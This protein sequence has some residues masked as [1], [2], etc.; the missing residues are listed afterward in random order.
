MKPRPSDLFCRVLS[1]AIVAVFF[2]H[3]AQAETLYGSNNDSRI[4]VALEVNQESVQSQ[5]PEGWSAIPFPGG[6]LAGANTLLVFVDRYLATG[7]DGKPSDPSTFRGVAFANLAKKNDSDE[8]RTY[9]TRLYAGVDGYDPYEN[10]AHADI[11]RSASI[12]SVGSN[13]P[14]R[15]ETWTI[16]RDGGEMVFSI[17]Y[18]SGPLSW[19]AGEALPYSNTKPDFHRIY[20]FD[21]LVDLAMSEPAGKPL[22]GSMSLESSIP[23]LANMFDGSERIVAVIVVPMYVRS[24]YLP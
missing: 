7:A 18:E 4:V 23:E 16:N 10:A 15:S 19:G 21:Q 1:F 14:K 5:I 8:V 24:V 2:A 12:E 3:A 22:S 17:D 13:A 9:V 6:A 20:R 11:A